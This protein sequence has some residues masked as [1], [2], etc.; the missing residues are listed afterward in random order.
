MTK[1]LQLAV[2]GISTGSAFALVG[3]GMVLIYRTTSIVNFAQ[4][5]FAVIGGLLMVSLVDDVHGLV[6]GTL[7]VVL[8]ALIGAV[9]GMIA[10]G[11]RTRTTALAS[12]IITL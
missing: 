4:G 10:V 2:V 11:F 6:A 8:V 1:F 12:L 5:A 3:I 9:M 7:A